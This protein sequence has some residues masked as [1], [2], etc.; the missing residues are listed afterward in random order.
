[1]IDL[2]AEELTE[3]ERWEII[4]DLTQ[5]MDDQEREEFLEGWNEK[6]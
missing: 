6:W 1:M 3:E 4:C 5:D 2:E